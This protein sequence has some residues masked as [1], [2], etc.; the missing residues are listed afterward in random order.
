MFFRV[1]SK[2][3]LTVGGLRKSTGGAFIY[4]HSKAPSTPDL[5]ELRSMTVRRVKATAL[6]VVK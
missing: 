3:A 5:F 2:V 6:S 4:K 1:F